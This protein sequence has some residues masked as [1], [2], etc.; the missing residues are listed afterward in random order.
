MKH[1]LNAIRESLFRSSI[2]SVFGFG[3]SVKEIWT[4]N[5]AQTGRI[6][7]TETVSLFRFKL[8]FAQNKASRFGKSRNNGIV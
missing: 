8:C 1:T 5:L 3:E 7:V 2:T 6:G 4:I